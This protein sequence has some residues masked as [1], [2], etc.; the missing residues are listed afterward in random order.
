MAKHFWNG[1]LVELIILALSV[2]IVIGTGSHSGMYWA[3][4]LHIPSSML[5]VFLGEIALSILGKAG[6]ALA[7]ALVLLMQ[8]CVFALLSLIIA[9]V[10]KASMNQSHRS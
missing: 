3:M 10:R 6:T 4:W 8:I 2:S 5:G 1:I 7:L 9:K